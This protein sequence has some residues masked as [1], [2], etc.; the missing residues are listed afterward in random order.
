MILVDTGVLYAVADDA[1]AD[2]VACTELLATRTG[3]LL[4]PTPL[5]V[6]TAWLVES[7][8]G[9]S[10]EVAFPRSIQ[11]GELSRTD[12]TEQDWQRIVELAETY[13]DLGLGVVDASIVAAAERKRITEIA[14]LNHRDFRVVRPTHT[15]AFT[16]LP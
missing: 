14:T 16:L 4:V 1:D 13:A 11:T 8:L 2:H 7:R 12:L 3:P 6:E 9:P 5:I 10:A 15:D